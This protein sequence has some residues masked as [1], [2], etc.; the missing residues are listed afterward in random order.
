MADVFL[1]HGLGGSPSENWL[2]WL[3]GELQKL[4]CRVFA[5]PVPFHGE[6]YAGELAARI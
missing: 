4:G 3:G 5:P 6:P 2:P 1:I